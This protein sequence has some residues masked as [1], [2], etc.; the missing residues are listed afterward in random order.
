MRRR[1][2]PQTIED[3]DLGTLSSSRARSRLLS[4]W[5]FTV[6]FGA[7]PLTFI[8]WLLY[9]MAR[10][11]VLVPWPV[12]GVFAVVC[13]VL[14]AVGI[15][16]SVLVKRGTRKQDQTTHAIRAIAERRGWT[17]HNRMTEWETGWT[18]APFASLTDVIVSPAAASADGTVTF[19]V[20]YLEGDVSVAG[21]A[22]KSLQTRLAIADLGVPLPTTVVVAERFADAV[23][24][25]VGG[26]D[27]DVESAE[28]NRLWRVK[29]VDAAGAHGLL[30][31]RVIAFLID[32]YTPGLAI[33][34]D[35]TR[36]LIWDDA[37]SD[38]IDLD[39][40]LE[41]LEGLV[42]RLPSFVKP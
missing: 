24:K 33:Q 38:T 21:S 34:F 37:T 30:T 36:V 42:E 7:V 3:P 20:A 29:T 32:E 12:V 16:L 15:P 2:A 19:G 35:G 17:S 4:A 9:A 10:R 18:L 28:F 26:K 40:R 6:F 31:P 41:L 39:E 11:N 25:L 27:L 5:G 13:A 1:S 14:W 8:T 23:A 22:V